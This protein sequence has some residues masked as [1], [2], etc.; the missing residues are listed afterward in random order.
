VKHIK[1]TNYTTWDWLKQFGS[2]FCS[3]F[4]AQWAFRSFMEGDWLQGVMHCL[5]TAG[6][7]LIYLR[8]NREIQRK[9]PQ[10]K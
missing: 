4:L 5:G 6:W 7:M 10:E 3:L 2:M 1:I 8:I 9:N